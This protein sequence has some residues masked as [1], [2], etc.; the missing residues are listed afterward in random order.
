MIRYPDRWQS[1]HLAL[2]LLKR[3]LFCSLLYAMCKRT[4]SYDIPPGKLTCPLKRDCLKKEMNHLLIFQTSIFKGDL[5]VFRGVIDS[6]AFFF[7][8]EPWSPNIRSIHSR[9]PWDVVSLLPLNSPTFHSSKRRKGNTLVCT[10]DFLRTEPV[11]SKQLSYLYICMAGFVVYF[12]WIVC[13]AHNG[14]YVYI[15]IYIS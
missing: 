12:S 2:M 1:F 5:L 11:W 6:R 15:Y 14:S 4:N 3:I 13:W 9:D 10:L 7:A 8:H